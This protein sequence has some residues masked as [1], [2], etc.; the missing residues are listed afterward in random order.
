MPSSTRLTVDIRISEVLLP[1]NYT[2]PSLSFVYYFLTIHLFY[3]TIPLSPT[4]LHLYTEPR[5]MSSAEVKTYRK[6]ERK[7]LCIVNLRYHL[8]Q[9]REQYLTQWYLRHKISRK[10]ENHSFKSTFRLIESNIKIASTMEKLQTCGYF[11]CSFP[12][13]LC[14]FS[15]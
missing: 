5:L 12:F 6:K 15:C 7:M 3:S 4:P 13:L 8:K 1:F 14:T 10:Y 2:N 11:A 9:R